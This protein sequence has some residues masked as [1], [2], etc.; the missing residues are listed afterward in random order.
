MEASRSTQSPDS[1]CNGG[2]KTKIARY[3]AYAGGETITG[4]TIV[5]DEMTP[6]EIERKICQIVVESVQY[7]L[8]DYQ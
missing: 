5:D 2:G 1:R 6:D 4:E 8:E 7:V 3:E